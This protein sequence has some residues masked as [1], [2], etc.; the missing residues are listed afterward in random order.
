MIEDKILLIKLDLR[1][2]TI[3]IVTMYV[4]QIELEENI[5]I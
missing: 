3:N 2:E 1:E 5:K 4:P